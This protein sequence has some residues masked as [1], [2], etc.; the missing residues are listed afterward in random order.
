MYNL[1]SVLLNGIIE[2][3]SQKNKRQ[4]LNNRQKKKKKGVTDLVLSSSSY[5]FGTMQHMKSFSRRY[6]QQLMHF[7]DVL[8]RVGMEG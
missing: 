3:L 6:G 7:V 5:K 4:K 1:Y 8:Y 2:F